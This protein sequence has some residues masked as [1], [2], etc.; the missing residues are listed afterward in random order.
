MRLTTYLLDL[1]RDPIWLNH[2]EEGLWQF[3]PTIYQFAFEYYRGLKIK[4]TTDFARL[5]Q[6]AQK[7][8]D[9]LIT[10]WIKRVIVSWR[11]KTTRRRALTIRYNW[12]VEMP[13]NVGRRNKNWSMLTNNASASIE[14]SSSRNINS[15]NS[16]HQVWSS[17]TTHWW[18]AGIITKTIFYLNVC[19]WNN[20]NFKNNV[21]N[22]TLHET[23]PGH[24]PQL[25]IS[26]RSPN[27]NYLT[28]LDGAPCKRVCSP[29][30]SVIRYSNV[31]ES[32][33]G[34]YKR[35]FFAHSASSSRFFSRRRQTTGRCD[36][37]RQTISHHEWRMHHG[38][39][40][41]LSSSFRTG[42]CV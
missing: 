14:R 36:R 29:N 2:P 32:I 15:K 20:G 34:I 37:T 1:I 13:F 28:A 27:N 5:K 25:E 16:I 11:T 42:L 9:G 41:S 21:E 23:V 40:L 6:W 8:L 19:D 30:I 33:T 7:H 39:D 24:H 3:D 17:W 38:W 35:I 31:L 12:S 10:K 26:Y 4:S 18:P 22:L